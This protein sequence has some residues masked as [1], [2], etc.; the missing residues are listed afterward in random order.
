MRILSKNL[1][2]VRRLSLV[3]RAQV[4]FF[5]TCMMS[6]KKLIKVLKCNLMLFEQVIQSILAHLKLPKSPLAMIVKDAI[7]LIL[8]LFVLKA[9][10]LILS[11]CL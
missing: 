9:N 5:K 10:T 2:K 1:S 7:V 3:S 4:V 8:I 6:Y 11:K